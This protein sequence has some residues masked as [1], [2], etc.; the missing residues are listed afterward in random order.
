MNLRRIFPYR[1][2]E[3]TAMLR[4]TI[5]VNDFIALKL[6]IAA[7]G[8]IANR[9]KILL[10]A[11][12]MAAKKKPEA[13]INKAVKYQSHNNKWCRI[14]IS[15]PGE[16]YEVLTD[17]RSAGKMNVSMLIAEALEIILNNE[18]PSTSIIIDNYP[19]IFY[20]ISFKKKNGRN[21]T[22]ISWKDD[23]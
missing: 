12:R 3:V 7:G 16:I 11:A 14:H 20:K 22:F 21:Y 18:N 10:A 17:R 1:F 19:S 6:Q 9:K 23:Q 2:T 8:K 13:R 5:S 4:T 15:L